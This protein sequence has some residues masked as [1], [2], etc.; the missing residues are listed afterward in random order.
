M[1]SDWSIAHEYPLTKEFMAMTHGWQISPAHDYVVTTKGAP[2]AVARLCKLDQQ[3]TDDVLQQV[4][5]LTSQGMRVLA[6]AKA[7]HSGQ[8]W[9]LTPEAFD[10]VWLGL[11]GLADPIRPEVPTAV[12]ECHQAGIRVAMITGDYPATAQAIVKEAGLPY[13]KVITGAQWMRF[14]TPNLKRPSAL[15]MS[16]PESFLSKNCVW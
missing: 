2:E 6:V 3:K 9:P 16:S 14:P 10:F 8:V 12:S 7:R 5:E 13:E 15:C 1:H 4:Q 11:V